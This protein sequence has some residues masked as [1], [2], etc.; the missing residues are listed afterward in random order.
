M[1]A[2]TKKWVSFFLFLYFFLNKRFCHSLF[3]L[4]CVHLVFS[5]SLSFLPSFLLSFFLS[6]S[7]GRTHGIWQFPGRG[8]SELRPPVYTTA[9]QYLS[10]ICDLHHSPW[11][12]W[13]L[14][15][16]S[17]ARDWNCNLMDTSQVQY[18]WAIM[19][20]PNSL[21]LSFFFFFFFLCFFGPHLQPMEGPRPGVGM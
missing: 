11:Q 2:D 16:L 14:N 9:T 19:G 1:S 20:T 15:P 21:F 13:I 6:D 18:C 8:Q 12:H 4:S 5:L 17:K 3:G 10:C 7:Y